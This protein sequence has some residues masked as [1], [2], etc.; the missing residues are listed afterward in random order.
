MCSPIVSACTLADAL[1]RVSPWRFAL[2]LLWLNA[3][4]PGRQLDHPG[5]RSRPRP[6]LIAIAA[7]L[8]ARCP[9]L[10]SAGPAAS[11]RRPTCPFEAAAP[12]YRD[13]LLV[14]CASA[15]LS[16][17]NYGAGQGG[18]VYFLRRSHGTSL[19]AG[20]GAIL[21]ASAGWL[22]VLALAAGWAFLAGAVPDRLGPQ[23]PW[24]G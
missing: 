19:E 17:L 2:V 20:A 22:A 8:P 15:L 10:R 12:R 4:R 13:I 16:L 21:L 1:G 23:G 9:N 24:P 3:A 14:R 6:G 11:T 7:L 5:S 18:V